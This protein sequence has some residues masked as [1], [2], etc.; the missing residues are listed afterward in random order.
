M[1]TVKDDYINLFDFIC[2]SLSISPVLLKT[3]L[4]P[5]KLETFEDLIN[6]LNGLNL[7]DNGERI[8]GIYDGIWHDVNIDTLINE[9]NKLDDLYTRE[10]SLKVVKD[11]K[12]NKDE[13]ELMYPID[14][15]KWVDTKFHFNYDYFKGLGEADASEL[16]ETTFDPET[17]SEVIVTIDNDQV[18]SYRGSLDKFFSSSKNAL[19]ARRDFVL[20]VFKDNQLV[21]EV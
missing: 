9:S 11:I 10:Y 3:I 13:V 12:K 19:A 7:V 16:K 8:Q 17:R 1:L 6:S 21:G 20:D 15:F 18:D 2:T 4:T 14:F 5:N